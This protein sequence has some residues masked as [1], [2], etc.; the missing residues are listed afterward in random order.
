VPADSPETA[1]ASSSRFS[2]F[3]FAIP[4]HSPFSSQRDRLDR[5][6]R[7]P[8]SEKARLLRWTRKAI[9]RLAAEGKTT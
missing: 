5:V 7:E 3:S 2:G 4:A 6:A 1:L 9:T 8:I